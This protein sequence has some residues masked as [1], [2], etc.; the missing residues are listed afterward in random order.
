MR[1][2]KGL[3]WSLVTTMTIYL[4]PATF[5][6]VCFLAHCSVSCQHNVYDYVDYVNMKT[7]LEIL[8]FV[9]LQLCVMKKYIYEIWNNGG[10]KKPQLIF[11]F[12]TSFSSDKSPRADALW[13]NINQWHHISEIPVAFLS[14]RK[15]PIS[16]SFLS[17][18][19]KLQGSQSCSH[20]GRQR[21]TGGVV[22][23]HYAASWNSPLVFVF[24][25]GRTIVADDSYL[26]DHPICRDV[27]SNCP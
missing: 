17:W 18:C 24:V 27:T 23:W 7:D 5:V 14:G 26:K 13:V 8:C 20:C 9:S 10:E 11:S 21:K 3:T 22:N 19:I 4:N 2:E 15:N 16:R 6:C 25:C 12:S 1:E